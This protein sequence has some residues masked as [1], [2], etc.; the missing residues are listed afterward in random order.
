MEDQLAAVF[1]KRQIPK[2]I[3][4]NQIKVGGARV[5][6]FWTPIWPKGGSILHAD[7]HS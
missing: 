6:Q 4:D 5:G 1:R 3:K 7:S 2:L